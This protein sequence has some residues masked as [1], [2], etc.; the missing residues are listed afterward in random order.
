MDTLILIYALLQ[1]SQTINEDEEDS[2]DS[3]NILV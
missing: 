1:S 2:Q 3:H